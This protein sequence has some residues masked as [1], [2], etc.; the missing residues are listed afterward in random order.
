[1]G[2]PLLPADNH[3][4]IGQLA[5]PHFSEHGVERPEGGLLLGVGEGRGQLDLPA[6]PDP[7]NTR[8]RHDGAVDDFRT[9]GLA[10]DG[11][12]VVVAAIRFHEV[13]D[14][15]VDV[16]QLVRGV[17]R[18]ALH[19]VPNDAVPQEP[20]LPV[21]HGQ[22]D[23]PRDTGQALVPIGVADVQPKEPDDLR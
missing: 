7:G 2:R 23:P 10:S 19:L 20:A 14:V 17:V 9:A 3:A 15:F 21:G 12:G 13:K 5:E 4:K 18:A 6:I 1:M 11:V 8:R 16:A 22:G